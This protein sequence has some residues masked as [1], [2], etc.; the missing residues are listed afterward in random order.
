MIISTI[1][2]D[3]L[4]HRQDFSRIPLFKLHQMLKRQFQRQ[5]MSELHIL[6]FNF[7]TKVEV[8]HEVDHDQLHSK[9]G[10]TPT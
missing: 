7:G 8:P 4:Y 1:I 9:D 2:Y 6:M 5:I 3:S 10:V